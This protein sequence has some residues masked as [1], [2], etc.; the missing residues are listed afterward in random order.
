MDV[1]TL[2]AGRAI[3]RNGAP[4]VSIAGCKREEPGYAPADFDTFA[5]FVVAAVTALRDCIT[6]EDSRCLNDDKR[7]ELARLQLLR[8]NNIAAGALDL[9][10]KSET[11]ALCVCDNCDWTG[12]QATLGLTLSEVHHLAERLDPGGEVPAGECPE[13]GALA[14]LK[15]EG[16]A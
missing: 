6:A 1:Y 3:R 11:G 10:P 16:D 2:E 8:I 15:K 9:L 4:F 5:R 13:C 12:G 14:Y 7:G